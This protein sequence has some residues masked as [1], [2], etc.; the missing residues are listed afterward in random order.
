MLQL[1][2]INKKKIAREREGVAYAPTP[3]TPG[4]I[5]RK[6]TPFIWPG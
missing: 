2:I 1:I 4:R 6:K 5:T 3:P